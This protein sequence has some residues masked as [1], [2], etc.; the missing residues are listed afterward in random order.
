MVVFSRMFKISSHDKQHTHTTTSWRK[1][2]NFTRDLVHVSLAR[3]DILV[4]GI[5]VHDTGT[6]VVMG[7]HD[8]KHPVQNQSDVL[9]SKRWKHQ[10]K[11]RQ[12][13]S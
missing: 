8:G 6:Q 7:E 4:V 2:G 9:C 5:N 1:R 11:Y 12:G 10:H 3:V 13:S